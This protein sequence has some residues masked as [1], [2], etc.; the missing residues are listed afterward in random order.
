MDVWTDVWMYTLHET[1]QV[2]S[3]AS[4]FVTAHQHLFRY[5]SMDVCMDGWMYVCMDG[6]TYV[7]MDV[8]VYGWMDARS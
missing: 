5:V 4:S 2:C 3:N 6:C 8:R 7:W 1:T